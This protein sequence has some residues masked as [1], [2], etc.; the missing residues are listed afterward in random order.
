[1]CSYPVYAGWRYHNDVL[2]GMVAY[3]DTSLGLA[4]GDQTERIRAEFVSANYFTVLG[5]QPAIGSAF[6]PEDERPGAARVAVI[7]YALWKRRLGG[8]PAALQKTIALNGRTFSVVGVAPRNYSG[9]LRG[10]QTDNWLALPPRVDF[11]G[12]P[13]LLTSD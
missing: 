2:S 7:S 1:M 13:N 9:V 5:I 4:A 12:D 3:V 6:A 11:E 10:I 8:E